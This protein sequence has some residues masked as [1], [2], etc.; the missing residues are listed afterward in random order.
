MKNLIATYNDS[1]DAYLIPFKD[2]T[3]PTDYLK[4]LSCKKQASRNLL[5]FIMEE[6]EKHAV[7]D[8]TQVTAQVTQKL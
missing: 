8:P 1:K 5:R 6:V 7:T 4:T 3:L 2:L